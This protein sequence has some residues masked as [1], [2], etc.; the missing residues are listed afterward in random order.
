MRLS[1][2]IASVL[3][4]F[5]TP[6][7]AQARGLTLAES[8]APAN[9]VRGV[10]LVIGNSDYANAPLRN[11]ANDADAMAAA[12]RELGF[13]VMHANNLERAGMRRAIRRFGDAIASSDGVGLFYYAGHGMQSNGRNYLIPIGADI[14]REDEL[15]DEAVAA[16]LPLRKMASAHNGLNIVILDACRNNPFARSFR[17]G[18]S[19]L[20]RMDAPTGTLIAYA[21]SPGSVA[22]DGQGRNSPYTRHLLTQMRIPGQ[23]IEQTFKNVRIGVLAETTGKQTPWE[24]S[25]LVG[26][27]AFTPGDGAPVVTAPAPWANPD[28]TPNAASAPANPFVGVWRMSDQWD[29]GVISISGDAKQVTAISFKGDKADWNAHNITQTTPDVIT[30]EFKHIRAPLFWIGGTATYTRLASGA[31]QVKWVSGLTSGEYVMTREK[32]P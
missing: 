1:V 8:G 16:D 29:T 7:T 32:S 6:L 10:A 9:A 25:S 11:P 20:A 4:L 28:A 26:S 19:G 15:P 2:L 23:P 12:L 17:S 30:F 3:A 14:A 22:A 5:L 31:I 18:N 24:S 13:T 27:F 21:T